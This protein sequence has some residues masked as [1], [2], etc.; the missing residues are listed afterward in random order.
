MDQKVET[1]KRRGLNVPSRYV[2]CFYD[3]QVPLIFSRHI[4]LLINVHIVKAMV[5]PV[6]MYGFES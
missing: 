4:T 1:E 3:E 6:V 2:C 5:F